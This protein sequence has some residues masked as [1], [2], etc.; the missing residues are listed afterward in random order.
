M[1][2]D[3]LNEAYFAYVKDLTAS[4]NTNPKR[5]WSFVKSYTKKQ[6]TPGCIIYKGSRMLSQKK[7]Q[8]L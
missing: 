7:K 3:N 4:L 6:N 1:V 5:F 2:K 8:R